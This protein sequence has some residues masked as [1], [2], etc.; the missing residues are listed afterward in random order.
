MSCKLWP[1]PQHPLAGHC[2]TDQSTKLSY[3][4][5]LKFNLPADLSR[6]NQSNDSLYRLSFNL[7]IVFFM[8][9]LFKY[10]YSQ[11]F[12]PQ[13]S[14]KS[15][16]F[17]TKLIF[18]K[19]LLQLLSRNKQKKNLP[20]VEKILIF[21]FVSCTKFC[22]QF[23]GKTV[24]DESQTFYPI[25]HKDALM[26]NLKQA[27]ACR[28]LVAS[29]GSCLQLCTLLSFTGISCRGTCPK[30]CRWEGRGPEGACLSRAWSP[31]PGGSTA[32]QGAP[33]CW[34][35]LPSCCHPALPLNPQKQQRLS[36]SKSSKGWNTRNISLVRTVYYLLK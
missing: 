5:P 26:A 13:N 36:S 11:D 19:A 35:A 4:Q 3:E 24:S 1:H 21:V 7:F 16:F 6:S 23:C 30:G 9:I 25:E 22:L 12:T 29:D 33:R 8:Y 18:K 20:W 17:K 34:A 31:A 27:K 14:L 15:D 28:L 10:L 32:G 2:F